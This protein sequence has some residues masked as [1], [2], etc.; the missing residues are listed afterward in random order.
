MPNIFVIAG[1][2][3]AGKST[4][5]RSLLPDYMACAEF[6]NADD[7]ARGLSAFRPES[8]GW[9]AGRLM[10][11]RLAELARS[12]VDFA[13]ET[14]LASRSFAPWLRQQQA[15]NYNVHLLY[16]WLPSAEMAVARVESRVRAGGHHVP[17]DDV[18]RRYERSRNNFLQL[19]M[20]LA[21]TWEVYENS[22]AKRCS[23]AFGG[24]DSPIAVV[25]PAIWQRFQSL[26]L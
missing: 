23:V 15:E 21:N 3:G 20:T 4:T 10:L 19:Y 18:R 8:V 1:P 16:C 25:E 5:A 9:E 22:G 26:K 13:F 12:R 11:T 7:I 6:V 2:N 24:L 17:E 14:T